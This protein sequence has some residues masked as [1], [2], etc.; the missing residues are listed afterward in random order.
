MSS[1]IWASAMNYN[2]V[3]VPIMYS[4]G[5]T[6]AF[7][8]DDEQINPWTIATQTGYTE[9]W[10]NKLQTNITLEQDF[11]FITKGLNSSDAMDS[12]LTIIS[13]STV[14]KYQ[15]YGERNRTALLTVVL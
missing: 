7:G 1:N 4:N 6:P 2:P 10:N 13:G 15:N 12:T 5:Y 14:K 9:T 3:S 11:S 8:S